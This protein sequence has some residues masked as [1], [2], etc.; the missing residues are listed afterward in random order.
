MIPKTQTNPYQNPWP[1]WVHLV[2]ALWKL[3]WLFLCSWTPKFFNPLR[4]LTLRAFGATISGTPFVH[5]KARIQIPWHLTMHHRACLGERSV[6]YSLGK[7]EI[8]EGATVAQEAY[9]C[10]ATHDFSDPSFQLITKKIIIE[11]SAFIGVRAMIMPGITI[12]RNAI[13]GAQSVVTKDVCSNEVVVGNP[14][15]KI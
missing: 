7:I 13:V 14:A 10:T 6:A 12:G 15:S 9:L 11:N 1:L 8:M 3:T 5:S 2:L 4:L